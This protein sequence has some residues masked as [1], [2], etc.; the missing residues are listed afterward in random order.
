MI[1]LRHRCGYEPARQEPPRR[2]VA[3]QRLERKDEQTVRR[4]VVTAGRDLHEAG[5]Q[6]T[7]TA[8]FLHLAPRTL[9]N[10]RHD[11]SVTGL[12][13]VPLGRPI[14]TARREERNDV[15]HFLDEWGPGVGLPTLQTMFPNLARAELADVLGRYRR[16]WRRR[17]VQPLH[18]LHWTTPGR[19]WAIDFHGPRPAVDGLHPHLLAV[20]DLASGRQLAW[21]PVRD[22]TAATVLPVLTSLF[23]VHDA[24]LVLKSDNGSAFGAREVQTLCG[25]FGVRNLFSPPRTPRYNGS[26]EAGIGSLTTRT[27]QAAARRG[28]PDDWTFNDAE[29]AR[30]EANATARPRGLNGPSPD[31]LWS[32]RTP[33]AQTERDAFGQTVRWMR[34]ALDLA[35]EGPQE[36]ERSEMQERAI[37]REA[38]SRALVE[39]GY[40]HYTRRRIY[41]PIRKQKAARII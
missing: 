32:A 5:W 41:P 40:L 34:T 11:F 28:C 27:E 14:R 17:H 38:I 29:L 24:P 2:G 35:Q 22:V 23:T 21:L 7:E 33:I 39:H 3:G 30:Q 4:H 20:R 12:R 37:N 9:R 19:V 16:V 36:M 26:I 15:I 13:I 25:Q 31:D 8:D 6:W 1:Y 10:W 18:V